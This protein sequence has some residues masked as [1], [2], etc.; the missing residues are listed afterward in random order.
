MRGESTKML[1]NA[2]KGAND[3]HQAGTNHE[4][5][6]LCITGPKPWLFRD[7]SKC[8]GRIHVV[9]WSLEEMRTPG[10]SASVLV[11]VLGVVVFFVPTIIVNIFYFNGTRNTI[12][13]ADQ[14]CVNLVLVSFLGEILI[15]SGI[16]LSVLAFLNRPHK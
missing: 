8:R 15:I 2:I 6:D 16:F 1:T 12:I 3:T 14:T 11:I 13:C 7:I 4:K 10:L 5:P 9:T